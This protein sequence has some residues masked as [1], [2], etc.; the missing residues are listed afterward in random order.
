MRGDD[1]LLVGA[2][3]RLLERGLRLSQ[4]R[5]GGGDLGRLRAIFD[6]FQPGL[7]G[8][9]RGGRRPLLFG[10]SAGFQL[11]EAGLRALQLRLG[12][13]HGG[14]LPARIELDQR[15]SGG[16]ILTFFHEHLGHDPADRQAEL[17]APH[18]RDFGFGNNPVIGLHGGRRRR[19][20][21]ARGGRA[22]PR[23]AADEQ[24]DCAD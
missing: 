12:L 22:S 5:L 4:R 24:T 1:L 20:G 10:A 21:F 14:S 17:R 16:H 9:Q 15:L 6:A 8:L 18:R 23:S 11:G 2:F 13:R 19:G 7:G 3:Q